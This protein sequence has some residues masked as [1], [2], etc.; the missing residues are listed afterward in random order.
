M[1]FTSKKSVQVIASDLSSLQTQH[2]TMLSKLEDYKRKD[3][4]LGHRLLKVW[5]QVL[6]QLYCFAGIFLLFVISF[7][8]EMWLLKKLI[9]KSTIIRIPLIFPSSLNILSSIESG[10]SFLQNNPRKS[11]FALV[12]ERKS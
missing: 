10:M 1:I 6:Y 4:E 5:I 12:K 3:L 2:S 9:Q 11:N 7:C 8:R